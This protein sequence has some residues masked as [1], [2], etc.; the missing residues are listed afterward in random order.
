MALDWFVILSA[1]K[2]PPVGESSSL[3]ES[4]GLRPLDD[5][6]LFDLRH[7]EPR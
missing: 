3:G 6:G 2:D 1:A 7:R 4:F 5:D